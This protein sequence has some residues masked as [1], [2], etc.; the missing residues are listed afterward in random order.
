MSTGH[1]DRC[2]CQTFLRHIERR[3]REVQSERNDRSAHVDNDE[4]TAQSRSVEDENVELPPFD[5]MTHA[6]IGQWAIF[7][8]TRATLVDPSLVFEM[9]RRPTTIRRTS[10]SPWNYKS[11]P[12]NIHNRRRRRK[13]LELDFVMKNKR[14]AVRTANVRSFNTLSVQRS[15]NCIS[16]SPCTTRESRICRASLGFERFFRINS[17]R[18]DFARVRRTSELNGTKQCSFSLCFSIGSRLRRSMT[19]FVNWSN[20][21][22]WNRSAT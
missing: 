6:E 8:V 7:K 10:I 1:I 16:C 14:S 9:R 12:K 18:N 15:A 13:R 21:S 5:E 17:V 2:R 20:R 19:T 22:G 11:L 3:S 4:Q